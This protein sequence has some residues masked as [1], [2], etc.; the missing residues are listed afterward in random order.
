MPWAASLVET[1]ALERKQMFNAANPQYEPWPY[2]RKAHGNSVA[3]LRASGVSGFLKSMSERRRQ[4]RAIRELEAMD[5]Y[6]LKDIGIGR[7]EIMRAV[8]YG[9]DGQWLPPL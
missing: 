7:S 4:R 6:M 5:D 8:R 2:E 1:P 9:R 3:R